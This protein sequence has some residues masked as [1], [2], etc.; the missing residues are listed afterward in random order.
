M[1]CHVLGG[2]RGLELLLTDVNR[3]KQ[4]IEAQ[5][6]ELFG[7][8][9][10]KDVM[11]FSGKAE[12]EYIRG[13]VNLVQ[14]YGEDVML[15]ALA[16]CEPIE[17]NANIVCTTAHKAKGREWAYVVVDRDFEV[18]ISR[19]SDRKASFEAELRLLYV[20]VTRAKTAVQLPEA[21]LK[22]FGLRITTNDTLGLDDLSSTETPSPTDSSILSGVISPYHSPRAGESKEMTSLRK[23]L[24]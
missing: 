19:S 20:A 12:G 11:S 18:S 8:S 15:R 14:E 3:V 24:G 17:G 10:W 23:I 5:S 13:L 6:P 22:R 9:T 4:G 1:R 7:F 16:R 21:I 2:T